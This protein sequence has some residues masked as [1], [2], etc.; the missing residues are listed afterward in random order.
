MLRIMRDS[1]PFPRPYLY[2][3]VFVYMHIITFQRRSL[4]SGDRC[5]TES[6]PVGVS[7]GGDVTAVACVSGIELHQAGA[8]AGFIK[9]D[10]DPLCVSVSPD[11]KF[12][13]VGGKVCV[14]FGERG[15]EGCL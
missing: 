1:V 3:C 11:G 13:A 15:G 14:C 8:K 6:C 9:A 5:P 10:W 2:M 7:K 4:F 12:V